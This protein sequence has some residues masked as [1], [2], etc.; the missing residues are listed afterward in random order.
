MKW[1]EHRN[2]LEQ[3]KEHAYIALDY[4]KKTNNKAQIGKALINVAHFEYLFGNYSVSASLLSDAVKLLEIFESILII[5]VKE[6]AKSLV[7]L[8]AYEDVIRLV[9]EYSPLAKEYPD[10]WGKL[11]MMY[12]TATDNPSHAEK[13]LYDPTV[14]KN[15]R[16]L[17]CK[18]L[19]EFY[20]LKGDYESSMRYYE[21]SRM[22]SNTKSEYL[23]E[24]GF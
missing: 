23:N 12:T 24:G 20:Y 18:S 17:A 9:D 22:I 8:G 13:V 1:N 6:Y 10:Y 19:M 11:Q 14:S 5:A 3:A 15:V 16:Y 2:N 7:Q 21:K 4:F